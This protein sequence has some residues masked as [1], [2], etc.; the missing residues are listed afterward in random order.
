MHRVAQQGARRRVRAH[1]SDRLAGDGCDSTVGGEK[2][3][4][5]PS[6]P[7]DFGTR[8]GLNAAGGECLDDDVD[9]GRLTT[10]ELPVLS[11]NSTVS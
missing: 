3:K 11:K 1:C 10:I 7:A 2:D 8:R 6:V 9:A 5:L 4:F